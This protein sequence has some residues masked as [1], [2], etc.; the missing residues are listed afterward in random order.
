MSQTTAI[1]IGSHSLKWARVEFRPS[2]SPKLCHWGRIP[3]PFD[4]LTGNFNKLGLDDR[5]QFEEALEKVV[6]EARA[7]GDEIALTFPDQYIKVFFCELDKL[8]DLTKK[9]REYTKWRLRQELPGS[10]VKDCILDYQHLTTVNKEQGPSFKIVV[11]AI[12]SQILNEMTQV[13]AKEGSWPAFTNAN[14]FCCF[15][16]FEE[17]LDPSA[18]RETPI[19]L[20]H[21]GHYSTTFSFF[22]NGILE[23][24]RI[25]DYAWHNFIETLQE[26]D[27]CQPEEAIEKLSKEE[28]LPRT[29]DTP[30]SAL[31][32][33]GMFREIFEEWLR[34]IEQTF[35]FYK[36]KHPY[37]ESPIVYLCGGGAV[38][39]NLSSF[40]SRL[41]ASPVEVLKPS[42]LV[43]FTC[44]SIPS[45]NEE[46]GL[47]A[48]IA[49]AV[50]WGE[51]AREELED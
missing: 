36:S 41:L 35:A 9:E 24:L 22:R 40:L 18:P 26:I 2:Q 43:E 46:I 16:L 17:K 51:Q 37:I 8:Q 44:P 4:T 13:V 34:E 21:I 6:K 20:I 10:I 42:E 1:D 39:K 47:S 32:G 11:E 23:Y 45:E 49:A 5:E 27:D 38:L 15:N 25:L 50:S 19:C 12:R 33:I 14:S 29:G 7:G 48:S 3:L 31:K 28:I 30:P